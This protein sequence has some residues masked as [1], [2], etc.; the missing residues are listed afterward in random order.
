MQKN[1]K[2]E[3]ETK[4]YF[5]TSRGPGG[6]RRD[7]KKT[8]IELHHLPSGIVIRVD[9]RSQQ[10]QNKKL[11]FRLLKEK[12]E[13][14][15]QPKKRRIRTRVPRGIKEKRLRK[16]KLHSTKKKLRSKPISM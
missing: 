16:K 5:S 8:G 1:K 12:L 9:E 13:K 3:K 15:R 4:L 14:L 11:A 6:Q 10:A 2:L 7:R